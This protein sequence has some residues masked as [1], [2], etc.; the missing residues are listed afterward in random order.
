MEDLLMV[1][2][3]GIVGCMLI[4]STITAR[5]NKTYETFT[6]KLLTILGAFASIIMVRVFGDIYPNNIIACVFLS[7]FVGWSLGPTIGYIGQKFKWNKFLK[8]KGVKRKDINNKSGFWGTNDNKH[9][10]YYYEGDDENYFE[11]KSD[12]MRELEDDFNENVLSVDGDPYNQAWQ[13]VVFQAMLSTCIAVFTTMLVV[14]ISPYN[15]NFL[16]VILLVSLIALI[17]MR[18]LNA[19]I[20]KSAKQMLYQSY[21]GIV[22]FTLYLVY[23]FDRLKQANTAGD[24]SW[25][26]AID[27]AVNIYLDIIN[28]FIELLIA[29]SENQ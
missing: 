20:F 15:F 18:I 14:Y 26:T 7:G 9:Y 24:N 28:L 1:R 3:F 25:G 23:D 5:L 11:L 2:T 17:I 13:N 27:I 10:V 8:D 19:Y 21:A 29:M 6:E 4:I 16:G 22:I 12:K